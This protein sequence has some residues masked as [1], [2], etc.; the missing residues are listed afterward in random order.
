[1]LGLGGYVGVGYW[2][3]T[4]G[5]LWVMVWAGEEPAEEDWGRW[6]YR[7]ADGAEGAEG[8]VGVGTL[9]RTTCGYSWDSE[10]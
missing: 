2:A 9:W 6:R 8:A 4:L 3:M 7:G 5:W 10:R 1:M